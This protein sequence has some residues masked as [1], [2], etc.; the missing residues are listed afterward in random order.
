VRKETSNGDVAD[1]LEQ[2]PIKLS[3]SVYR[4]DFLVFLRSGEVQ[5][6]EVKGAETPMWKAKMRELAATRPQL[7]ARL[8][9]VK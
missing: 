1:W 9:V 5:F 7:F 3:G 6:V 8:L 2:V 4:V